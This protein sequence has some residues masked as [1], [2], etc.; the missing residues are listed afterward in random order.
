MTDPTETLKKKKNL[1]QH[2]NLLTH[3]TYVFLEF[4][5]AVICN[6]TMISA[7]TFLPLSNLSAWWGFLSAVLLFHEY[8]AAA[9]DTLWAFLFG[10]LLINV[11]NTGFVCLCQGNAKTSYGVYLP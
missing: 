3:I 6:N 1:L 2:L 4:N 10:N 9:P 5:Q 7:S 8:S 11:L